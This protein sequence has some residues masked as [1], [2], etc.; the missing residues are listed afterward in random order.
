[1]GPNISFMKLYGSGEDLDLTRVG[2]R[3]AYRF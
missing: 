2:V 3:A 1:M